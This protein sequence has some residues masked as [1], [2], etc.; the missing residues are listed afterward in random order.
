MRC[1]NVGFINTAPHGEIAWVDPTTDAGH[2][3]GRGRTY[4]I[5]PSVNDKFPG[6]GISDSGIN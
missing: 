6:G 5:R 3:R 4:H 1:D 2:W